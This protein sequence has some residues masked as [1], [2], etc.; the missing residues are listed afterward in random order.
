M[1]A[2]MANTAVRRRSALDGAAP[3]VPAGRWC[4]CRSACCSIRTRSI[5]VRCRSSREVGSTLGVPAD[6][7]RAG[8]A[9]RTDDDRL[10]DQ[11]ADAG[12]LPGRGLDRHRARRAP[13]IHR[14]VPFRGLR[15][16]DDRLR[17]AG[18][19]SSMKTV[20]IGSGAGFSGDRIEPAVELATHGSLDYL[21]LECLAE[22]TIALAQA[23][24]RRIRRAGSTR[25]SSAGSRPSCRPVAST[26][27]PSS[28]TWARRIRRAP[29]RGRGS[30]RVVSAA[31]V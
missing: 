14:P 7:D 10:S 6:P 8:G 2:A 21:V 17:P 15:R 29:G 30:W 24:R 19:V 25:C 23:A 13:A 5:S 27:S 31:T 4:R 3:A 26:V 1:L 12:D 20:R 16:H 9:P 11:P 22:R 18:S 28:P